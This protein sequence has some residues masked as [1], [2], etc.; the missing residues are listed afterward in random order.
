VP[1]GP[2]RDRDVRA[3]RAPGPAA[4]AL[5]GIQPIEPGSWWRIGADGCEQQRYFDVVDGRRRRLLA[6]EP[7]DVVARFESLLDDSVRLHLASDVPL[8]TICSGG[9]DSS[10]SPPWPAGVNPLHCY[11]ADAPIT[12]RAMPRNASPTLACGSRAC[13]WTASHLRHGPTRSG[14]TETR[15]I[16]AAAWRCWPSR[17]VARTA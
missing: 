16:T 14:T 4:D 2:A 15:A 6:P 12:R 7:A 10:L 9:V 1:A 3:A 8:A 13:S 11:V 17:G 5:R